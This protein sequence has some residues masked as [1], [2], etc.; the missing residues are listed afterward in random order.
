MGRRT[1][2]S[3][4]GLLV[5]AAAAGALLI[6]L[7][8]AVEP[9]ELPALVLDAAQV[10]A[11]ERSDAELAA[12][13]ATAEA[14]QLLA[15]FHGFGETEVVS[16][17][18]AQLREQR[19]HTLHRLQELL[20][21]KAGARAVLALRARA[22]AR[23]EAALDGALEGPDVKGWLGVFPNVLEQYQVT[24]DGLEVAPHFVVRT[25]YKAR[26]NKLCNLPVEADLS[27]IERQAYFGWLGLHAGNLP[28]AERRQALVGYA[29]AGG[30]QAEQAQGVLAYLDRDYAGAE[31]ALERAYARAPSLRLRNYLRG[32]QVA[33][34]RVGAGLPTNQSQA[35]VD[36]HN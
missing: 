13:P 17:D 30:E 18:N 24:R 15:L 12:L 22:L 33:A 16:L 35:R 4:F 8:R 29:A 5:A 31:K 2:L 27:P 9:S 36:G 26:W 7:P 21:Q 6:C 3:L 10:A 19:R 23:L 34:G 11:Q 32:A 1:G 20:R 28:V 25:L 14:E